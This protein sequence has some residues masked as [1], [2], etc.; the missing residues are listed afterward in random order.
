[1]T[2][3]H[4]LSPNWASANFS[5]KLHAIANFG[6]PGV[7]KGIPTVHW[8]GMISWFVWGYH[9]CIQGRHYC[10]KLA[11]PRAL[12]KFY[13]VY[14]MMFDTVPSRI[15]CQIQW[16]W[17]KWSYVEYQIFVTVVNR[18]SL[19]WGS[20]KLSIIYCNLFRHYYHDNELLSYKGHPSVRDQLLFMTRTGAEEKTILNHNFQKPSWQKSW[21]FYTPSANPEKIWEPLHK[22]NLSPTYNI[23]CRSLLWVITRSHSYRIRPVHTMPFVFFCTI[24]QNERDNLRIQM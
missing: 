23:T 22:T 14:S 8:E 5:R 12:H 11:P 18:V 15:Q 20:I 21:N 3:Y 13:W 24:T 19:S 10:C 4:T 9:E 1:M 7:Q 6:S 17:M 16:H 2:T